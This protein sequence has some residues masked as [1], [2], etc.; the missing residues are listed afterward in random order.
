MTCDSS[1]YQLANEKDI[2]IHIN[3]RKYYDKIRQQGLSQVLRKKFLGRPIDFNS[4]KYEVVTLC[5]AEKQ[6]VNLPS[7]IDSHLSRITAT[8]PTSTIETE[9]SWLFKQDL[10]HGPTKLYK[11]NDVNIGKSGIWADSSNFL[12]RTVNQNRDLKVVNLESAILVDSDYSANYFG[13]W[14]LDFISASLISTEKSPPFSTFKPNYFH[15]N[16]YQALLDINNVIYSNK[17]FVKE[18]YFLDDFFTQNSY[19]INRYNELRMRIEK[20]ISINKN[21]YTGVYIARGITGKKRLLLN[22]DEL[23]NH[24]LKKGFYII[25][26]EKKSVEEI[27][28]ILLNCPFIISVEGSEIS[29]AIITA[30]KSAGYLILMPPNRCSFYFKG[31]LDGA[32]HPWGFYICQ[33]TKDPDSFYIDSFSDLD[34]LIDTIMQQSLQK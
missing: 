32:G 13:H 11:L 10:V 16:G 18:L 5:E 33:T 28:S 17:G 26:P 8:V 31:T 23:I 14:L 12:T 29:H 1:D 19:K 24:L 4:D 30:S 25:T 21:N 2:Y 9:L 22:E 6:Y 34:R 15:A 20:K 7:Y 3:L 27:A